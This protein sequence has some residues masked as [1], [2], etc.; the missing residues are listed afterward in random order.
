MYSR[1]VP[2]NSQNNPHY[3]R[4]LELLD[5]LKKEY[6]TVAFDS[7]TLNVG[8]RA[9]REE[10]EQKIQAQLNEV[11]FMQKTIIELE[12]AYLKMKVNYEEEIGRLRKELESRTLTS[13]VNLGFPNPNVPAIPAFILNSSLP[14]H[15]PGSVISLPQI[16]VASQVAA[17]RARME[18]SVASSQH[19]SPHST[20]GSLSGSKSPVVSSSYVGIGGMSATA[21]Y[22]AGM[23]TSGGYMQP[24][25]SGMDGSLDARKKASSMAGSTQSGY[26]NGSHP[27]NYPDGASSSSQANVLGMRNSSSVE[28]AS[29]SSIVRHPTW[30]V[31]YNPKLFKNIEVNLLETFTHREVVSC[32][33]FS[34]NNALLATGSNKLISLFDTIS[35][36]L[37]AELEIPNNSDKEIFIRSVCFSP[38]SKQLAVGSEDCLIRIWDLESRQ[39][40][41]SISCHKQEVYAVE[42]T[43]DGRYLISGSG[44]RTMKIISIE[45][46][47][48]IATLDAFTS[49]P[50]TEFKDY[51][52]TSVAVSTDGSLVAS[53][54]ID[55]TIRIWHIASRKLVGVLEGH[56]NT[57][58]SLAFSPDSKF[59][60]SGSLDKTINLWER[61]SDASKDN[62]D[63]NASNDQLASGLTY[64]LR[65]VISCHNHFVLSVTFTP[66]SKYVVSCSKDMTIHVW[67]IASEAFQFI[68]EGHTDTVFSVSVSKDSK[69]LASGSGDKTARIWELS[70]FDFDCDSNDAELERNS[71]NTNGGNNNSASEEQ[72]IA[73]STDPTSSINENGDSDALEVDQDD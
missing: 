42:Y 48:P 16:D 32:V 29:P 8:L 9:Y 43:P 13:Q 15:A 5:A 10:L 62:D 49:L 27:G 68:L 30:Q 47:E 20:S 41:H 17:K 7:T 3:N 39:V 1:E 69:L 40:I 31:T 38:D 67:N 55:K 57:I 33:R 50:P 61:Q 36:S 52:V 51:G 22:A 24:N 56:Q 54:C 2:G 4:Y 60:A 63:K 34:P 28:I 70:S 45:E 12:R 14:T 11:A 18:D 71:P 46:G 72:Q 25:G 44:D 23:G 37:Y 53:G 26:P 58:Y 21:Q 19:S 65:Q 35:C 73:P 64:K 66:D 59:I 6:E